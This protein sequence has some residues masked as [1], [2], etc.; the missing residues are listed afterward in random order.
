MWGDVRLG[1]VVFAAD[2]R[3]AAVLDWEMASFGP[4]ES[5]VSWYGALDAMTEHFVGARVPGFPDRATVDRQVEEAIGRELVAR[6]WFDLWAVT[7]ATAI[8][9]RV[10]RV[11]ALRKGRPRPDPETAAMTAYLESELMRTMLS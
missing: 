2:L 11:R 9:L 1:N 3:P 8:S 7:R 10:D 4:I 6:E 5:D